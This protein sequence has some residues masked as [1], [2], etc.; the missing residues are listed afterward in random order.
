VASANNLVSQVQQS[1]RNSDI[2]GLA[3]NLNV[4]EQNGTVT[5]SGY[6]PSERDKQMAE[7]LARNTAGVSAINNQIQVLPS[8]TGNNARV[9]PPSSANQIAGDIFNLH[10][11][12]LNDT[13]R[14]LAQ[15]ILESLRTDTALNSLLPSVNINVSSGRVV[16]EGRVQSDQQRK[17]I[18]SVVRQASGSGNVEDQLQVV[19]P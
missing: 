8:P 17:T 7:T 9:Y 2:S 15:R 18:E 11:Q 14:A 1:F 3:P 6:V 19:G 4:S 16:L 5:L 12:G 13:D 10:V